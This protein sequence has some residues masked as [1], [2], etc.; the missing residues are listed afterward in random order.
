MYAAE[1]QQRIS[2]VLLAEGR[3][4]VSELSD[5]L[6]VTS[7][8]VRRDLD[9]LEAAGSL[10]RVHG[11]AVAA[12]RAATVERPL[13]VRETEHL[14]QKRAAADAAM[15][16]IPNDASYSLLLDAGSTT[17]IVA[18]RLAGL[19]ARSVDGLTVIC[20]SFQIIRRLAINPAINIVSLG[21][22]LRG[23]TGAAVGP[24]TLDQLAGLR[25]DVAMVG[26]NGV[27]AGFGCSTPDPDEAAVKR[28]MV[29]GA[30]R[31]VVVADSSKFD[32][33]TLV[34]FAALDELDVLATDAAP[35][36]ELARALDDADV[37]V[38]T[39]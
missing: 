15:R 10:R 24:V 11:G 16:C 5:R 29:R 7:E 4:S 36:V 6:R 19:P 37:E 22:R 23:V 39:A 38:M 25:P 33:S 21:G 27:S 31:R 20:N 14:P 3:V 28:A 26:T 13:D 9:A 30:G 12:D 34:R 8:T 18:E 1:R 32:A 2:E 17:A 35:A